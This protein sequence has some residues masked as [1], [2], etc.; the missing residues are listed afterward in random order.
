MIRGADFLAA[1]R[2]AGFDTLAGVPCSYLTPLMNAAL[3][4]AALGYL[5]AANEGEAIAI[6]AGAWLAGLPRTAAVP[7][8][9]R[10]N[11]KRAREFFHPP[12]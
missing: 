6:A 7:A 8:A 10:G 1:A 5:S 9:A 3:A 4:D 2:A 12:Q 11:L